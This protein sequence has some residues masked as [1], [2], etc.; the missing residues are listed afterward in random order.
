MTRRVTMRATIVYIV[1]V[2]RWR[3]WHRSSNLCGR[4]ACGIQ[5]YDCGFGVSGHLGCGVEKPRA[6]TIRCGRHSPHTRHP[7][8]IGSNGNRAR[9]R[10]RW[11]MGSEDAACSCPCSFL[12]GT[13]SGG[14]EDAMALRREDLVDTAVMRPGRRALRGGVVQL[15]LVRVRMPPRE[16]PWRRWG[17]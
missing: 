16:C 13:G 1:Q 4:M 3:R 8:G 14:S 9:V 6:V 12:G 17:S 10:V 11:G 2:T 7:R 15:R 5:S